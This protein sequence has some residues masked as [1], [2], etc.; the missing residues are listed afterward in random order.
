MDT[1]NELSNQK[2]FNI[3][4]KLVKF[5]WVV[6]ILAVTTGFLISI[7]VSFS[8]YAEL[9]KTDRVLSFGDYSSILVAALPFILVAVVEAAKIAVATALM[10]AKHF[11]WHILFFIGLVLLTTIT[12]ETISNGFKK[13]FS[14]LNITIDEKK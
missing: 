4:V 2:L 12:F 7:I 3:G 9:N 1:K 11:W 14:G 6:E 8:V 13:K 5:A 10:L